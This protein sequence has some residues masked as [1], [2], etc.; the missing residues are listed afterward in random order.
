MPAPDDGL[1]MGQGLA[2]IQECASAANLLRDAK[3][4]IREM[5]FVLTGADSIFTL[6]SIGVEKLMKVMLG[7]DHLRQNSEWPSRATMQGWGHGVV[8]M[9]AMLNAA[10]D[11]N[12]ELATHP[13]YVSG[14]LEEQRA[15]EYWP[16]LVAVLD[17][18]GRAGRFYYLDHLADGEASDWEPPA[19][20]WDELEAAIVRDHPELLTALSSMDNDVADAG[21]RDLSRYVEET[22]ERWWE[23][24]FR[25]SIQGC[26]GER[27]RMISSEIRGFDQ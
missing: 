14:L 12:L 5:R 6:T 11:A 18:Y 4:A 15:D 3:R 17:R 22:L 13:V 20:Y 8:R 16:L 21:R 7:L 26:F 19:A 25:F 27:A 2:L 9:N 1:D 10:L 24:V 23:M